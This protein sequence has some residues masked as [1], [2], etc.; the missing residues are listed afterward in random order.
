MIRKKSEVNSNTTKTSR[1]TIR[2]KIE[3]EDEDIVG[4]IYISKKES[5]LPTRL[6]LDRIRN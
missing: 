1:D 2:F 5:P 6:I 4:T 3:I